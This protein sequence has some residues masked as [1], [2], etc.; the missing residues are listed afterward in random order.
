ML[1]LCCLISLLPNHIYSVFLAYF[2]NF[3]NV[4]LK[5]LRKMANCHKGFCHI[6]Y[7]SYKIWQVNSSKHSAD[8]ISRV[9]DRVKIQQF[10]HQYEIGWTQKLCSFR[11]QCF[12]S[13]RNESFIIR[14][15]MSTLV[16]I[17]DHLD[18]ISNCFLIA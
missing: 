14:Q 16:K 11:D 9:I 10:L 6:E 4:R 13:P 2:Q 8:L 3:S 1:K 12:I 15:K 17:F 7:L 18:T 5:G